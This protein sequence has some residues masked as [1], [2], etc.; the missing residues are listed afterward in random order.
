MTT[1]DFDDVVQRGGEGSGEDTSA[2]KTRQVWLRK[3]VINELAGAGVL[4]G[5]INPQGGDRWDLEKLPLGGRIAV[6]GSKNRQ[7]VNGLWLWLRQRRTKQ[8]WSAL[9]T[10]NYQHGGTPEVR[11]PLQDFAKIVGALDQ[12]SRGE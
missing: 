6:T 2:A 3:Q 10:P 12:L 8:T 1:P 9:V 7:T 4:T 11:I 5:L